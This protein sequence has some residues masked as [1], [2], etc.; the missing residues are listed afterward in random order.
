MG[1]TAQCFP[2][3]SETVTSCRSYDICYINVYLES[4]NRRISFPLFQVWSSICT[5]HGSNCDLGYP[6]EGDPG[7]DASPAQ[8]R[9]LHSGGWRI[10][11]GNTTP[12]NAGQLKKIM[13]WQKSLNY[14]LCRLSLV[15]TV[16]YCI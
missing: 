13:I 6:A 14:N 10:V 8:A 1:T 4:V 3:S 5:V 15:G 7:E 2:L 12:Q 16:V 9:S 11:N